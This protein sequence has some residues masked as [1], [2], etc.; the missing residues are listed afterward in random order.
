MAVILGCENLYTNFN[1][2]I[3]LNTLKHVSVNVHVPSVCLLQD[4][5]ADEPQRGSCRLSLSG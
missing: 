4:R 3:V 5:T 2:W 1:I